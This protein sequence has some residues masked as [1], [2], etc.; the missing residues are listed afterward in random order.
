LLF[1]NRSHDIGNESSFGDSQIAIGE[2]RNGFVA[3][4]VILS[5]SVDNFFG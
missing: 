1:L 2:S 5:A 3:Q 4:L